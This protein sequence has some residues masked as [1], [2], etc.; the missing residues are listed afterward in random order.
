[1]TLAVE[2]WEN[3]ILA[4]KQVGNWLRWASRVAANAAKRLA[5]R[6]SMQRRG[7]LSSV[8]AQPPETRFVPQ[9]SRRA[10]LAALAQRNDRL[11]GRQF[12][13]VCVLAREGMSIHRAAKELCMS[14]FNLRRA[15]RSAL[16][17]L[18]TPPK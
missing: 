13:V 2:Q 18:S 11:R 10:L 4:G 7:A 8:D 9:A 3:A 17:R 1:M 6:S 12:E 15:F 14:R 5:P 16:R